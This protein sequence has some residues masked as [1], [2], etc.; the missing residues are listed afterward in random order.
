[1]LSERL[2]RKRIRLASMVGIEVMLAL[3]EFRSAE[4]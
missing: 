3:D 4:R 1:M 2:F